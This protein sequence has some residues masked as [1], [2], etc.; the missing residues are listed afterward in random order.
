MEEKLYFKPEKKNQ[1]EQK[2]S[3]NDKKNNNKT[4]RKPFK[5][6]IFLL[7]I[8][9]LTIVIMWLLCGNNSTTGRYPDNIKN[10]SL[11][12]VSNTATPPKL[13]SVDS[14]IKEVKIN[15]IFSGENELKRL[16]LTYSLTY[17]SE[18]DAY[19]AEAKSHAFLNKAFASSGYPTDKFDNKYSRYNN[20]LHISFTAERKDI[21]DFSAP[22]FMLK[23]E[24]DKE[25]KNLTM[26]EMR[27]NYE[28][29]GF[30]CE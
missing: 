2:A 26:S 13:D 4:S 14:E 23:T 10:E 29:Q 21:D 25:L 22:Y 30:K 18:E 1:K 24:N 3:N 5:L 6:I 28:S 17:E 7:F 20:I 19:G 16:Y 9:V 11:I 8:V 27:D 15:A 12:C